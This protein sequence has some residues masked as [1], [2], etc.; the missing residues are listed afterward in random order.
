MN[1]NSMVLSDYWWQF[2]IA[3][4]LLGSQQTL[5]LTDHYKHVCSDPN[6]QKAR[7]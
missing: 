3:E 7:I 4:V 1:N 2:V 5:A 6:S